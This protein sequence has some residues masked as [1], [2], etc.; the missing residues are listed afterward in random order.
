MGNKIVQVYSEYIWDTVTVS[1]ILILKARHVNISWFI[2]T[3]FRKPGFTFCLFVI[4]RERKKMRTD[5]VGICKCGCTSCQA[6][7]KDWIERAT[8]SVAM[9][10][11]TFSFKS[12]LFQAF[13]GILWWGT[14]WNELIIMLSIYCEQ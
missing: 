4:V 10:V 13:I 1:S 5:F 11:S 3:I 9:M 12:I 6:R 14:M 7:M 8:V 2:F